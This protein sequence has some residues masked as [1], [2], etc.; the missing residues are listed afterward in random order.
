MQLKNRL[1]NS[2]NEFGVL[3]FV[4]TLVLKLNKVNKDE[5]NR[6]PFI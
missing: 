3:K 1:K 5:K 4:I 6:K 2:L